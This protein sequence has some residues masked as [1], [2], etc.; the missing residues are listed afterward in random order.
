M[1]LGKL[2]PSWQTGGMAYGIFDHD[3]D[4]KY[5]DRPDER[6]QFPTRYLGRAHDLVG[7]WVIYR[8]PSKVRRSR[9]YFAVAQVADVV[10]DP[11]E[12]GRHLALIAP[13]TYLPFP[14]EVPLL[15]PDGP[16]E[17][18]LLN[19]KGEVRGGNIQ[20]AVRP[21]PD[22]EFARIVSVGLGDVDEVLPRVDLDLPVAEL[23]APTI[24]VAEPDAVYTFETERARV[25]NLGS[26]W[27]RDRVF[28][29]SV[30]NAYD[31]RCALTGLRLING[32]GRAEAEAAHI[33]PVAQGGPDTVRNGLALSGT[34]HWMFD[35][36]L[37]SLEDDLRILVSRHV[38]DKDGI[39]GILN[40]DGRAHPPTRDADRPHPAFLEWHRAN[41]F[42]R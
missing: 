29:Q 38:N 16:W 25:P 23:P 9:G 24:G 31:R 34:V 18:G 20:W 35:R 11:T 42:K 39:G 6:Y 15:G 7:G 5:D 10:P 41:C 27:L 22:R 32:G 30:L 26:R 19:S 36:G 17:R 2:A 8:E 4:S 1:T 21:L 12:P 37:I 14:N 13:G 3:P 40:V 33:Q 28:R